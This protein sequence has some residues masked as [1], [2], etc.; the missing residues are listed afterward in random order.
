MP[1]FDPKI[2]GR[3]QKLIALAGST[4]EHEARNAAFLAI[5]LI[6][7]YDLRIEAPPTGLNFESTL[8][9]I[10]TEIRTRPRKPPANPFAKQRPVPKPKPKPANEITQE[11]LDEI[12]RPSEPP[13]KP[14]EPSEEELDD[15]FKK[16]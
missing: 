13:P 6:R 4:N 11:E 2:L 16:L 9:D 12:F 1:K 3:V 14:V 5:K 10:F 8:S 15:L 7:E